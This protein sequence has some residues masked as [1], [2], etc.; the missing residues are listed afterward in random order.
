MNKMSPPLQQ[1]G[2][3][4]LQYTDVKRN[5]PVAVELWYPTSDLAPLDEP[6]DGAWVHP[7]EV[8]NAALASG[9]Y[10]LIVMSHGHGG[11]RRDRSWLA[12]YLVHNGFI[13]ASVEHHGNSWRTYNPLLSLRFWERARDIS[14]A[15]TNLLQEEALQHAIH[16]KRI[17][18]VGYSLGGMTGLALG[19]AKAENVK[20]VVT[21]QTANVEGMNPE[22]LEQIDFADAQG[23]FADTR[24]KAMVLFAPAAFVFP[25]HALKA[26]KIPTALVASRNDEVLPFKEHAFKVIQYL[27]PKKLKLFHDASHHVFLNRASPMQ[28]EAIRADI[29][30]PSIEQAR[31]KLH[32]EIGLFVVSF[33]KEQL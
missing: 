6:Q 26:I 9:K 12:D 5:R 20:E 3:R 31:K 28:G 16:P 29:R 21:V 19:G 32:A 14:F 17:G 33:F 18:F 2:V 15:L 8:R 10:P 24:I 23:S 22:V 7:K 4:T 1:I 27:G 13:V 30:T 25:P 11:D